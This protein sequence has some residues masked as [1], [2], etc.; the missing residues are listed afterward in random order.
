MNLEFVHYLCLGLTTPLRTIV[1]EFV[2]PAACLFLLRL[3]NSLSPTLSGE[4]MPY[5]LHETDERGL[6]RWFTEYGVRTG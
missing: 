3:W 4:W 1:S 2:N 5:G 6:A